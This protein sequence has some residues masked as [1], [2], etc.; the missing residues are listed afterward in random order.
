MQNMWEILWFWLVFEYIGSSVNEYASIKL[1]YI[2]CT[3]WNIIV[4]LVIIQLCKKWIKNC[5]IWIFM[6]FQFAG[7]GV[8]VVGIVMATQEK[9]FLLPQYFV[10]V[11]IG[12]A[13]VGA[14][15]TIFAF[16]GCWGALYEKHVWITLV[17]WLI[18]APN[19]VYYWLIQPTRDGKISDFQCIITQSI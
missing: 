16:M 17:S 3:F 15:V 10:K 12:I 19:I 18:L 2:C 1:L 9:Y 13:V 8:T 5:W 14:C 7:I 11:A 6:W 4:A